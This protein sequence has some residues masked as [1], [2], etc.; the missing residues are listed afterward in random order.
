[1]SSKEKVT[2]FIIDKINNGKY[3]DGTKIMSENMLS[4]YLKVSRYSVREALKELEEKDIIYK[5]KG[6][7]NYIKLTENSMKY[8]IISIHE[9]YF[10]NE[11][12]NFFTRLLEQLKIEIKNKTYIPYIHLEKNHIYSFK[13]K[14]IEF[15]DSIPIDLKDIKGLITIG[16]YPENYKKFEEREIPIISLF[17][18]GYYPF[19]DINYLGLYAHI[20]KLLKKY[21]YKKVAI[22][23]YKNYNFLVNIQDNEKISNYSFYQVKHT[24]KL[25]DL[26]KCLEKE[27]KSIKE[28]PDAIVFLDDTLYTASQNLFSKYK[29]FSNCPIITHSNG[30]EIYSDDFKICKL[31]FKVDEFACQSIDLLSS[32]IDKKISKITNRFIDFTIENEEVLKD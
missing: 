4:Y 27:I 11:N 15:I 23:T 22:F 25:N 13:N 29:F 20:R 28:N 17:N 8:I 7:G 14:K 31:V 30:N 32:L 24:N 26:N 9:K 5:V 21:S 16:G 12:T 18:R 1:M 3:T 10:F 6:S 19:V 2:E